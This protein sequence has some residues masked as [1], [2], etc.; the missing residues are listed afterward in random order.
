M[1]SLTGRE[2]EAKADLALLQIHGIGL[3]ETPA[4][5]S[6]SKQVQPYTAAGS[7]Q[8]LDCSSVSHLLNTDIIWT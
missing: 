7:K 3:D 2:D 6:K 8:V 1:T 4:T 5:L